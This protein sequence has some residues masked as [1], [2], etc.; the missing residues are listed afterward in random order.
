MQIEPF[1]KIRKY[2][3]R[4]GRSLGTIRDSP[5]EPEEHLMIMFYDIL[6]LE[7]IVYAT[8][9]HD[10]RRAGLCSLVRPYPRSS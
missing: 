9:S 3:Q 4:S 5:V 6:L 8:E 7:D 2:V 1:H 10:R